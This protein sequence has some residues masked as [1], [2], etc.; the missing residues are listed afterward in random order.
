MTCYIC[1]MFT[2]DQ[3]VLRYDY[4]VSAARLHLPGYWDYSGDSILVP[5][6]IGTKDYKYEMLFKFVKDRGEWRHVNK[7]S[8]ERIH[9]NLRDIRRKKIKSL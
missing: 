1:V 3:M 9:G 2:F 8:E 5:V 7:Y 6:D 4:G